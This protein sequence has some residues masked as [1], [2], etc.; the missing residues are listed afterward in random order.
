MAI[1]IPVNV[2]YLHGTSSVYLSASQS[3]VLV[4]KIVL[5]ETIAR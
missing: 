4:A 2:I 5:V 3:V 1:D